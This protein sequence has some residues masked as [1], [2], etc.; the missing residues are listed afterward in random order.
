MINCFMVSDRSLAVSEIFSRYEV[1]YKQ[2]RE[3]VT[4]S[5]GQIRVQF[6]ICSS[7]CA[8]NQC[9]DRNLCVLFVIYVYYAF[10]M[11][12]SVEYTPHT[13]TAS[14]RK[15]ISSNNMPQISKSFSFIWLC[16]DVFGHSNHWAVSFFFILHLILYTQFELQTNIESIKRD[17]KKVNKIGFWC[18]ILSGALRQLWEMSDR[19]KYVYI[20]IDLVF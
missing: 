14:R 2:P 4:R 17:G 15:F 18:F 3:Y 13:H 7:L 16:F 9:L 19:R 8:I 20:W 12:T 6:A 1:E 11:W 5:S 10:R